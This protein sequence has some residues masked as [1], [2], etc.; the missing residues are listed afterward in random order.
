MIENKT[1]IMPDDHGPERLDRFLHDLFPE[2]SRAYLQQVIKKG[3][4]LLNGKRAKKG[5][6]VC[7][8]DEVKI[9]E[10]VHPDE[11]R[12]GA[13][14]RIDLPVV[15][16]EAEFAVVDKPAGLPTHP[17]N[18]E[19]ANT[20]ANAMLAMH[21]GIMDVG[22]DRLRPG[23]VH[24]LDTNTSGLLIV[25]L[26]QKAYTH[27]RKQF[28]ERK[29]RKEYI[30]L[31]LGATPPEG[32]VD[33]PLAH[34]PTD[35]RRMRVFSATSEV[36]RFK[37]RDAYTSYRRIERFEEASLLKVRT[38]TGRMHQV[39]V[40]L[41]AI[42]HPLVGDRLYQ[43]RQMRNLDSFGLGRHF[44]HAGK[45]AFKRPG[46]GE[47]LELSSRLPAELRDLV[48]SLRGASGD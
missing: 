2:I 7:S 4:V 40:H 29:V 15:H 44:L 21:P 5:E 28:D 25:A 37:A 19:D 34:H 8:G 41:S 45:L 9:V 10:M 38:K 42:G 18:Y 13:N 27:L 46:S 22:E 43:S 35:P 36:E 47:W 17:N 3:T 11:R 30:A 48:E 23:I 33:L 1:Y 32:E 12:I 39:R 26:T 14:D 16:K 20:V 6:T 24:R 31:V